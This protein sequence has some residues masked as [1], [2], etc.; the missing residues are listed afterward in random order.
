M[1]FTPAGVENAQAQESQT[2]SAAVK[3]EADDVRN[4]A[5][6]VITPTMGRFSRFDRDVN[7]ESFDQIENGVFKDKKTQEK[8]DP[9]SKEFLSSHP[10]YQAAERLLLN[11]PDEVRQEATMKFDAELEAQY[12]YVQTLSPEGVLKLSTDLEQQLSA[13]I[14][15]TDDSQVAKVLVALQSELAD[16]QS[17]MQVMQKENKRQ[18]FLEKNEKFKLALVASTTFVL[19]VVASIWLHELLEINRIEKA[20]E[21]NLGVRRNAE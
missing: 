14:A 16:T 18:L 17:A 3:R 10:S 20:K 1:A 4:K 7:T 9:S 5:T 12:K 15:E 19:T 2:N 8:W 11:L 13:L 21:E 6:E